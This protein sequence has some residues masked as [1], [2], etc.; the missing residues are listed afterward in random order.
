MDTKEEKPYSKGIFFNIFSK[1]QEMEEILK[2]EFGLGDYLE[3]PQFNV[4]DFIN[5]KFPSR[6]FFL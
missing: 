2:E 5:K 1:I 6:I 4:Y 3:N